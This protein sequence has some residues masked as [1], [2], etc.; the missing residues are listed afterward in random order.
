MF[1]IFIRLAI[2]IQKPL[3]LIY[4]ENLFLLIEKKGKMAYKNC[5]GTETNKNMSVSSEI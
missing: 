5:I 2:W 1:I 3:K 4:D